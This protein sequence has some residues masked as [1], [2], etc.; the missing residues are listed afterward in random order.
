MGVVLAAAGGLEGLSA[1]PRRR[2]AAAKSDAGLLV[3]WAEDI[4]EN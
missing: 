4:A 1:G 3:S 2:F